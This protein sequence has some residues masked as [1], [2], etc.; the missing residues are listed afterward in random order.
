MPRK[1]TTPAV[2]PADPALDKVPDLENQA[3]D[4]VQPTLPDDHPVVQAQKNK[5]A[6]FGK[7]YTPEQQVVLHQYAAAVLAGTILPNM[8]PDAIC[9]RAQQAL[10]V[11]ERI[12]VQTSKVANRAGS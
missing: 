1:R 2:V 3:S 10:E 7:K 6:R 4:T 5:D 8:H 11:A 9:T 12:L